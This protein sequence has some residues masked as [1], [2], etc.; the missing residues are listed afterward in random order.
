MRG[1]DDVDVGG[2]GIEDDDDDGADSEKDGLGPKAMSWSGGGCRGRGQK[3]ALWPAVL[4]GARNL[5][6]QRSGSREL[7]VDVVEDELPDPPGGR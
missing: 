4:C 1:R 2:D 6:E 7:M 5:G 3:S